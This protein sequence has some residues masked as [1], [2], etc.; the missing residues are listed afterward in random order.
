MRA[1][2]GTGPATRRALVTGADGLIGRSVVEHLLR[3][4]WAVTALDL[5]WSAS[6]DADRV[7]TGDAG[8]ESLVS[9]AL[10]DVTAVV[11]LGAIPHPGLGTPTAVFGGNT[12][13]TFNVL[14]QAGARGVPRAVLA[15][16]I[17][18]TG[19][20]MNTHDV[21]P[22][23][24]PLDEDAPAAHDDWYSLSK[25]VDELSA[26]MAHSR[27]GIDVVAL[28]FPLVRG[29]AALLEAGAAVLHSPDLARQGRE[30]WAYLD[31]RDAVS[32]IEAAL[33]HPLT[34]S[35]V[36]LAAADDILP[37]ALT[38]DLLDLHAPDV[39][40]RQA[41]PGRSGLVDTRRARELL[42]WAP[43]HSVHDQSR[44]VAEVSA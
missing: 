7:L 16:S 25:W 42:G 24:F 22:D 35:H 36:V 1:R 21:E 15:S 40:R 32:V 6:C 31:L 3:R 5:G 41:F 20:P 28:R 30:G 12:T 37:D 39:P 34:G 38:E 27:W 43:Q 44:A 18:A 14:S 9:T 17:N 19:V 10:D 8:S 11:H 29:E 33:T 13:A 23:Y 4:G 2:E 26:S